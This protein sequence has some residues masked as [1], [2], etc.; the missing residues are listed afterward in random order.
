M[1]KQALALLIEYHYWANHK[2]LAGAAELSPEQLSAPVGLSHGSLLATLA[3]GLAAEYVWRERCQGNSPERLP[4]VRDFSTLE[5]LRERWQVEEAA[6]RRYI[7][8]LDDADLN[9]TVNYRST[10]GVPY[11]NVLWQILAHMINH[12]TQ[13]RAEAALALTALGHSPG[14]LDLILFLREMG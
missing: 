4:D 11:E 2:I 5:A 10:K 9:R 3:H 13:T 8:G 7:A 1:N 12:G 14:D 6:M